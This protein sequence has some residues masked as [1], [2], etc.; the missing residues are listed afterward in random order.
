MIN[1]AARGKTTTVSPSRS[2]CNTAAMVS[3]VQ[4]RSTNPKPIKYGVFRSSYYSGSDDRS[5]S[6]G[7]GVEL[8]SEDC[9]FAS[10]T[11]Q[12]FSLV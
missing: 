5:Q 2:P 8:Q 6:V 1:C 10:F 11:R 7:K 4:T 12:G 3:F 9:E